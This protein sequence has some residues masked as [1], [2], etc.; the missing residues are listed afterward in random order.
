MVTKLLK[1]SHVPMQRQRSSLSVLCFKPL[2]MRSS[3]KGTA[4]LRY[5]PAPRLLLL[6]WLLLLVLILLPLLLRFPLLLLLM[7]MLRPL[8]LLLLLWLCWLLPLC[9]K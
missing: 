2:H 7:H 3:G 5:P 8:T 9:M 6:V 4:A 1:V